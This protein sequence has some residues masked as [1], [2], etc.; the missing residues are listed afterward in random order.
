MLPE[1]VAVDKV[2]QI[3]EFKKRSASYFEKVV[4]FVTHAGIPDFRVGFPGIPGRLVR[5]GLK[6]HESDYKPVV[7]TN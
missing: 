5:I 4:A 1:N 3:L 7:L 2:L 6:F